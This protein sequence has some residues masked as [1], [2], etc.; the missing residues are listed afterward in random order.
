[1]MR[2]KVVGVRL[3]P[4]LVEFLYNEVRDGRAKDVSDA[5]RQAIRAHYEGERDG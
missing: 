1:M 3:T 5:A 2:T 4:E